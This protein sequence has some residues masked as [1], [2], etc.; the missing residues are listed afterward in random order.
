MDKSEKIAEVISNIILVIAGISLVFLIGSTL[1]ISYEQGSI[2]EKLTLLSAVAVIAGAIILVQRRSDTT[3]PRILR[4]LG[5]ILLVLW[6]LSFVI[7][8]IIAE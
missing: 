6:I 3:L 8:G 7:R 1:F 2:L 4:I 5:F